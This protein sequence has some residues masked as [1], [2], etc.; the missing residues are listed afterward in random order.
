MFYAHIL[1]ISMRCTCQIS[2][3]FVLYIHNYQYQP[4]IWTYRWDIDRKSTDG[5]VVHNYPTNYWNHCA[6]DCYQN[7]KIVQNS[8]V[9]LTKFKYIYW[10]IINCLLQNQW[11][12]STT[13]FSCWVNNDRLLKELELIW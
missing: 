6:F 13:V 11:E 7:K 2:C 9:G 8:V 4:V 12:F 1:L 5:C 10:L 3:V